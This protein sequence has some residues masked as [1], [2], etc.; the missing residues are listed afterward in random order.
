MKWSDLS[1]TTKS[2]IVI[3]IAYVISC[4]VLMYALGHDEAAGFFVCGIALI[5]TIYVWNKE[6]I[7][8]WINSDET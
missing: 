5:Y 3:L 2:I 6:A 1:F 8:T 7:T 4:I